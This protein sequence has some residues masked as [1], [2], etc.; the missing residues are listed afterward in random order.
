MVHGM[1]A[2]SNVARGRDGQQ[3]EGWQCRRTA[4]RRFHFP[5]DHPGPSTRLRSTRQ[6][7]R[8]QNDVLCA[9]VHP[10][11]RRGKIG[12]RG[13]RRQPLVAGEQLPVAEV[14]SGRRS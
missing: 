9:P 3:A 7:V 8:S 11:A 1:N 5:P 10:H 2:A 13:I 12:V 14:S 6:M 4:K